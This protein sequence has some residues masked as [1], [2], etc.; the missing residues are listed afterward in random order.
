M[1]IHGSLSIPISGCVRQPQLLPSAAASSPP[2][3]SQPLGHRPS[4]QKR[5]RAT[6]GS[7]ISNLEPQASVP[8]NG[9]RK[10]LSPV[11]ATL[12]CSVY[13]SRRPT[14]SE[15]FP[16]M[17]AQSGARR[18]QD[19]AKSFRFCSYVKRYGNFQ[20]HFRNHLYFQWFTN[21][22]Q[23][24]ATDICARFR[25]PNS[26]TPRLTAAAH[27]PTSLPLLS[28]PRVRV[29][30]CASLRSRFRASLP[31]CSLQQL[32]EAVFSPSASNRCIEEKRG[33]ARPAGAWRK[34]ARNR[35][36]PFQRKHASGDHKRNK[37][38][39]LRC[40][41]FAASRSFRQHFSIV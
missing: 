6:L 35:G 7:P 31:P 4:A 1:T 16:Q 13:K 25:R 8:L 38:I 30:G 5:H 36:R 32:P 18:R 21:T 29:T 3:A 28:P 14:H 24:R 15:L 17:I 20:A 19:K 10:S 2:A 41:R 9:P 23:I 40:G 33:K 39:A 11:F 22:S 34:P 37:A 26:S 12:T 27:R